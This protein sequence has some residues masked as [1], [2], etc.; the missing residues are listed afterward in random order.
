MLRA[1]TLTALALTALTLALTGPGSAAAAVPQA[2]RG[3]T[4]VVSRVS[5]RV[6]A[7]R[8]GARRFVRVLRS[9]ALPVGTLVDASGGI[10]AVTI[11][12]TARDWTARVSR[13]STKIR[14][15]RGGRT[16]F[17]VSGAMDCPKKAGAARVTSRSLS[18]SDAGGPFGVRG[19][20]VSTVIRGGVAHGGA[21]L[22]TDYCRRSVVA[23]DRGKVQATDLATHQTVTISAGQSYTAAPVIPAPQFHW[24]APEAIANGSPLTAISCPTI[25][26]CAAVDDNGDVI[27]S[28]NP[29]GG[30]GAWTT[31]TIDP[32]SFL[33]SISCPT[34]GFCLAGGDPGGDEAFVSDNPSGGAGAWTTIT[35]PEGL[36]GID[37]PSTTLCVG[38]NSGGDVLTSVDPASSPSWVAGVVDP[39]GLLSAVS[40][41]GTSL[42][43]TVGQAI[44]TS[45]T[46]AGGATT[47]RTDTAHR[48]L[49]DVSCPST[50]LCVIADSSGNVLVSTDPTRGPSDYTEHDSIDSLST[51]DPAAG[52][53]CQASGE[54]VLAGQN[55]DVVTTANAATGPWA[56]RAIDPNG[57]NGVSC[58]TATE[59]VAIDGNGDV[60]VGLAAPPSAE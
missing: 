42:C 41:A 35:L 2:D 58:P 23:V 22:T 59:C 54:C 3:K 33:A 50:S 44:A 15:T 38:V 12:T 43:V 57:L 34:S 1:G 17:S 37:C 39:G 16:T 56:S 46:P 40:C 31:A 29:S 45:T 25:N 30:S 21:W 55:G 8:P 19:R 18:V 5:G 49:S 11:S 13:G 53:G 48:G 27:T 51:Y 10:A 9:V 4:V 20:Y 28:T 47:W 24:S 6:R 32:G 36:E 52:L 60:L 26:F 14:Q 7:R